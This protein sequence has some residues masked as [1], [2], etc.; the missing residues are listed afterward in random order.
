MMEYQYSNKNY[1]KSQLKSERNVSIK[2]IAA[3]LMRRCSLNMLSSRGNLNNSD[4]NTRISIYSSHH[5]HQHQ[6]LRR[7]LC[8]L[9]AT[10]MRS[11]YLNRKYVFHVDS[12]VTDGI[13]AR[14]SSMLRFISLKI[15]PNNHRLLLLLLLRHFILGFKIFNR[16]LN[17]TL[18]L[19]HQN[20]A[21][22]CE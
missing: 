13:V 1:R 6:R 15:I 20:K 8:G 22:I 7:N 5:H 3:M 16:I 11:I 19:F 21:M 10:Q 4:D 12:I 17:F 9:L 2:Q 18:Q 14:C